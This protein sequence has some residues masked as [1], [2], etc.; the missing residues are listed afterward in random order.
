MIDISR[1]Q[2]IKETLY[3]YLLNKREETALQLAIT[4]ANIRVVEQP[5]GSRAPIAPRKSMIS[6]VA[7]LIGLVIPFVF[8][9]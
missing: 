4:E 6:L 7:M 2:K 3:T 1:Q 9:Q 8:H 5:F